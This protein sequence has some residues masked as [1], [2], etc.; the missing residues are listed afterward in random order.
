MLHEKFSFLA[1][2]VALLAPLAHADNEI[3]SVNDK[4]F[5]LKSMSNS[6]PLEIDSVPELDFS[7]IPQIEPLGHSSYWHLLNQIPMGTTSTQGIKEIERVVNFA[8][9]QFKLRG[10][11]DAFLAERIEIAKKFAGRSEYAYTTGRNTHEI[12]GSISITVAHYTNET[13]D[14]ER[15]PMEETHGWTLERPVG[16]NGL[17]VIIEARTYAYTSSRVK[18]STSA[19][20]DSSY[21]VLW[22]AMNQMIQNVLKDFPDLI[23][24]EIVDTYGDVI[25]EYMYQPMGFKKADPSKFPPVVHDGITWNVLKVTPRVFLRN[26]IGRMKEHFV[27]HGLKGPIRVPAPNG[28]KFIVN[29]EDDIWISG[30]TAIAFTL[31]QSAEIVPGVWADVGTEVEFYLDGKLARISKLAHDLTLANGEIVP[32]G[33]EVRL[34]QDG[35]A[36]EIRNLPKNSVIPF[37]HLH[38]SEETELWFKSSG[39]YSMITQVAENSKVANVL[40]KPGSTVLLDDNNNSQFNIGEETELA[41]NIFAAAGTVITLKITPSGKSIPIWIKRLAKPTIIFGESIPKD[42]CISI[43]YQKKKV[44]SW[45]PTDSQ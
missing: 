1:I 12:D 32:T 20:L 3:V 23:D 21:D 14:L 37:T 15:L 38:S 45:A 33:A 34:F 24:E 5:C 27:A 22:S 25:S 17:G 6:L 39:G 8:N 18:L 29:G 7:K 42:Y 16:V 11:P 9:E 28:R 40:V 19:F 36:Y 13:K 26:Y 43:D 10:W 30:T 44:Y 4:N 35:S 41:P 31:Y 2:V